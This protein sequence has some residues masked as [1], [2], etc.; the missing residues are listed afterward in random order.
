[1]TEGWYLLSDDR[2]V[3]VD[4]RDFGA[5]DVTAC[6]HIVFRLVG[7]GGFGDDKKRLSVIW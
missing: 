5:L 2:H 4:S 6:Q 7:A 3:H 1:V